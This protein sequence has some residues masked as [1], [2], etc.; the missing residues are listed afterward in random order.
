MKHRDEIEIKLKVTHRREMKQ[1]IKALGFAPTGPRVHERNVLYD[2]PDRALAKTHCALRLR[3]ARGRHWLT[4]KGSPSRSRK[5]K[6]REEIETAVEDAEQLNGILNALGLRPVFVYQKYRTTY[7]AGP[8]PARGRLPTLAFDETLAGDYVELEGAR[9]WISAVAS[10]LGFDGRDYITESYVRLLAAS[11]K[12]SPGK[13]LTAA[14]TRPEVLAS[15][16]PIR[17]G[18]KKPQ[19]RLP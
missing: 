4:F 16:L 19:L 10:Q 11:G 15:I 7:T 3:S 2:F 12:Q 8:A 18:M 6:I 5:F 17:S 14:A 9:S 13:Q 1:Q